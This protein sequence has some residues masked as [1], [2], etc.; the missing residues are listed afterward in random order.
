MKAQDC[1]SLPRIYE[2]C[3]Y[4]QTELLEAYRKW[5]TKQPD[6]SA[7]TPI[8]ATDAYRLLLATIAPDQFAQAYDMRAHSPGTLTLGCQIANRLRPADLELLRLFYRQGEGFSYIAEVF[9]IPIPIVK[10]RLHKAKLRLFKAI[11]IP[12]SF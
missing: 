10:R 6:I 5:L 3:D 12:A 8:S 4:A 1:P 2:A 7:A 9:R 11:A